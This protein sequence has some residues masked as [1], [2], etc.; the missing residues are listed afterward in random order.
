M[1]WQL[2]W[3][4]GSGCWVQC[5]WPEVAAVPV[6]TN[7]K[8]GDLQPAEIDMAMVKPS[9]LFASWALAFSNCAGKTKDRGVAEPYMYMH[10]VIKSTLN[11]LA[12][13]F[14]FLSTTCILFTG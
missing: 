1:S 3:Q 14:Q 4:W 5:D 10:G 12:C 6:L 7:D 11:L 8:L 9:I 2:K 13:A